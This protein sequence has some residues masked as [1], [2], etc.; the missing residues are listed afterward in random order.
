MKRFKEF[1]VEGLGTRE[2]K[3]DKIAT[4]KPIYHKPIS[5]KQLK[6]QLPKRTW[7]ALMKHKR[8]REFGWEG[9]MPGAGDP[10][11]R[12]HVDGLKY[13]HIEAVHAGNLTS[14]APEHKIKHKYV[15]R[16]SSTGAVRGSGY[17]HK[18]EEMSKRAGRPVWGW[19][20]F[21]GVPTPADGGM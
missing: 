15:F 1:V 19:K 5:A 10:V 12:H 20:D 11:F 2:Y 3:A 9:H 13:H 18:D 21:D 16:I 6:D 14:N 8:F 4:D 17:Q 7:N